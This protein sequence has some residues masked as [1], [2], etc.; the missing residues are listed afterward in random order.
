MTVQNT[1][2]LSQLIA[3]QAWFHAIKFSEGLISEGRKLKNKPS[4]YTLYGTLKLLEHIDLNKRVCADIGTMDGLIAF[5][6]KSQGA[7]YVLATDVAKRAQFIEGQNYLN[8]DIDYQVPVRIAELDLALKQQKLDIMVCAGVLYH[9]FEPLT[10]LIKCREALKNNGLLIL[11]TQYL[12]DEPESVMSFSPNDMRLGNHHPNVFFVP[13]YHALCG[14]LNM[15]AFNIVTT[16]SN[17]GR[18]TILAKAVKPSGVT[19]DTVALQQVIKRYSRYNNYKEDIDYNRLEKESLDSDIVYTGPQHK[20][21]YLNLSDIRFDKAVLQPEIILDKKIR[22]RLK[23]QDF[24]RKKRTELARK[25]L[26]PDFP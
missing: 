13:S 15:A 18:I 5:Q 6:L 24:I 20:D 3:E 19:T 25:Q 7:D 12:S 17:H 9:V 2:Q 26:L 22:Y 23:L 4:N 14:M 8:L 16:I 1:S 11:E 10:M 21:Y